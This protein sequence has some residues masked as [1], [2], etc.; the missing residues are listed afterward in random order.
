MEGIV[1]G[2]EQSHIG[3]LGEELIE[4]SPSEKELGILMDVWT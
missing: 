3:L 4:T 1:P 2:S